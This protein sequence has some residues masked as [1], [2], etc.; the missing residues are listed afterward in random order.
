LS[1]AIN[2]KTCVGCKKCL[3]VCPGTLIKL[4]Q[5][6]KAFIKYPKDCWGCSSC[7]KE[8]QAKAIDFY[9]G[10]DIGGR[11]RRVQGEM[12]ADQVIWK[13]TETDGTIHVIEINPKASNQY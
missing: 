3:S 4:N 2:Q 8:C 12:K 11:G 13:I 5:E 7:I 1:I 6:G 9:L 10:A